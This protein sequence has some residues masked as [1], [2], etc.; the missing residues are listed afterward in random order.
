[1]DWLP[2]GCSAAFF[3]SSFLSLGLIV[4]CFFP[5]VS[6][7]SITHYTIMP[8]WLAFFLSEFFLSVQL[9][10]LFFSLCYLQWPSDGQF[11][12]H[13]LSYFS[14]SPVIFGV[15]LHSSKYYFFPL[16][17]LFFMCMWA[18]GRE[19]KEKKT[20]KMS[21]YGKIIHIPF[22]ELILLSFTSRYPHLYQLIH[23][24]IR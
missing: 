13:L 6:L 3:N 24:K 12:C 4:T 2:S 17:I 16:E 21:L 22:Y 9:N 7:L 5:P 18:G 19:G 11:L 14:S 20:K 15:F 10:S 1:M 8:L 23:N